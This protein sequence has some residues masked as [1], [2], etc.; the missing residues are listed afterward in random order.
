[1]K[2]LNITKL[3]K[4]TVRSSPAYKK[5]IKSKGFQHIAIN[6][7][8]DFDKIPIIDKNSYLYK[9]KFN[10]FF[11]NNKVPPMMYASSG[12]SGKPTFW[13]RGDEQEEIGGKIHE[14]IFKD[15]FNIKKNDKTLVVV[16]FS[17]GVW[18][19]GNYTLS[20]CRYVSKKGYN[21]TT[22]TPGIEKEDILNILKNIA[23][24]FTNLIIAGYP[25]FVM[26]IINECKARKINLNNKGRFIITAGDK[27][28]ENW[29]D[30]IKDRFKLKALHHVIGIY[31]SADA[32]VLGH[33]TPLTIF[34]RREALKNKKIYGQLFG[35]AKTTPAIVQFHPEYIYFENSG[36]ELIL[37]TKTACPLI[38]YN[39]HDIG[40]IYD[41]TKIIE[42]YSKLGLNKKSLHLLERKWGMPFIVIK[43]RTDVAVTFYAINIYPEH[44]KSC[45][46]DKRISKF[47]S[48]NYMAYNKTINKGRRQRLYI[49]LELAPN[50]KNSDHLQKVVSD[51]IIDKLA[52]VNIEYRKLYSSI[53]NRAIPVVSLNQYQDKSFL[54]LSLRSMVNIKGKKPKMILP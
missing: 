1:M 37:T 31:G 29:R 6:T 52:K 42:M 2:K 51:C 50:V 33:E 44:I 28:D 14:K 3:F 23:P 43:G 34:I 38:R 19:A 16:C 18:V 46:E 41:P 27:F 25:P 5:F 53:N 7:Q 10:E 40:E 45:L 36:E 12:S 49:K 13:A 11:L 17:M 9:Y 35:L 21:L 26:D 54:K 39:I 22:I 24:E 32:G 47:L 20:S 4:D 15:I 8:K 30:A 48:G